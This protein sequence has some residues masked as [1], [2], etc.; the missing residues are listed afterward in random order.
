[1]VGCSAINCC[2]ASEKG[3]KMFRFP[4]NAQRKMKWAVA[5]RRTTTK[6]ALWIP[7]VGARVCQDHFVTGKYLQNYPHVLLVATRN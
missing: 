7:G 5:V 4:W 2:G 3:Q 1:M 6:G